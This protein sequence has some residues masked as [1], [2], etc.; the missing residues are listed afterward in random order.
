MADDRYGEINSLLCSTEP[1]EVRRGLQLVKDE[2]ARV[3]TRDARPLFEMISA[4]FYYDPLDHPEL[5][6]VLDDAI[7]LVV[8]FGDWII[9]VLLERI[10]AGDIKAQLAI[11]QTLGRIGAD[12][13]DPLLAEYVK[14]GDPVRRTFVLYA[15]GKVQS[16]KVVAAV[17]VGL[18]AAE[19]K[20]LELRDTAVRALGRFAESVPPDQLPSE[21]RSQ[22]VERLHRALADPSP[23]IRSKAIRSLGKMAKAGHMTAAEMQTLRAVCQRL[24]GTDENYDWDRAYIVRKQAEEA[25]QYV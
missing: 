3:G 14:S 20:E 12:A 15:L 16:P 22:M 5:M 13:I 17:P 19:S 25:I 11:G 21:W 6:G 4:L 10:D 1:D 9:P 7:T 23:G 2:I 18:A 8:G 24:L